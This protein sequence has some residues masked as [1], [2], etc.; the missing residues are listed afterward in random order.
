MVKQGGE[1]PG[2]EWNGLPGTERGGEG[3]FETCRANTGLEDSTR[4]RALCIV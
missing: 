4:E 3:A 2:L 1:R